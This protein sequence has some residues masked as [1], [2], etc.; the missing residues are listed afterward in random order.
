MEFSPTSGAQMKAMAD[1]FSTDYGLFSVTGLL[2]MLFMAVWF[3]RFFVRK[4]NQ[5]EQ[6][7]P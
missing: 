3:Y 6:V 5:S 2:F 4:M 1:L 7:Q